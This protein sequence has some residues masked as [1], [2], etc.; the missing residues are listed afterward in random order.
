MRFNPSLLRLRCGVGPS[1]VY[2]RPIVRCRHAE[3]LHKGYLEDCRIECPLHQGVFDVRT[4]EPLEGPVSEP[5]RVFNVRIEGED[6]LI[7]A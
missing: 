2:S 3:P 6:I 5:L 4:G 1:F 7:E